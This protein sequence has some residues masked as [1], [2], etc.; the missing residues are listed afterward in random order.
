V[1]LLTFL[2]YS[3]FHATRKAFSNVKDT[4]QKEWTRN[5]AIHDP[6]KVRLFLSLV[7]LFDNW[8]SLWRHHSSGRVESTDPIPINRLPSGLPLYF[9]SKKYIHTYIHTYIQI[10]L[11][12]YITIVSI[13]VYAYIKFIECE[14]LNCLMSMTI[15]CHTKQICIIKPMNIFWGLNCA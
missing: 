1:F 7:H 2:S 3:C 11:C 14:V 12:V 15:F 13:Y 5:P 10:C 8:G 6:P 9:Y 4:M